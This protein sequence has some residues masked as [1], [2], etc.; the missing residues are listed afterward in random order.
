MPEMR[1][2]EQCGGASEGVLDGTCTIAGLDG[3]PCASRLLLGAGHRRFGTSDNV[4]LGM[5]RQL[6]KQRGLQRLTQARQ[7]CIARWHVL[8]INTTK[9][10]HMPGCTRDTTKLQI[11]SLQLVVADHTLGMALLLVPIANM[12]TR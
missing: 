5:R 11:A 10:L 4:Q 3:L 12:D 2:C 1:C 9:V 8:H 7:G 6:V